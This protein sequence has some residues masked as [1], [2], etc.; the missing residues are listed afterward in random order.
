MSFHLARALSCAGL[1]AFATTSPAEAHHPGGSGNTG[2]AGPINTVGAETL[3]RGQSTV[4]FLFEYTA[5]NAISDASL[6]YY[7]GKHQHVHS[8]ASIASP[9]ISLAYGVTNDLTVS[10]RLPYVRRSDIREGHH[11]HVHGGGVHNEAVARGN[12]SGIGDAS[13]LAQY[14]IVNNRDTGTQW[15]LLAG[16]KA[17]T[18]RTGLKDKN[19]EAFEAE[20][21]PGTGSWD[22]SAGLAVS[23]GYGRWGVHANVLQTWVGRSAWNEIEPTRLGDRFQYNLATTYRLMGA[24]AGSTERPHSHGHGASKPHSHTNS[25]MGAGGPALDVM[26]ELNGELHEHQKVAGIID[27]HSGGHTAYLAPGV[28]LS[29]DRWSAFASVGVPV[30][31]D[32]NGKQAEPSARV[33]T[34]I[35]VSF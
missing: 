30:I 5:L 11:E 29:N 31:N 6:A 23:Q 15:A 34:G 18:G 8:V 2:S 7:A 14:R 26:L 25:A 4:A 21:S 10:A 24:T 27:P 20:F 35:A 16:I 1:V 22:W 32:Q 3:A 17:P 12:A 13:L 9:A 19:G 33:T 28:R